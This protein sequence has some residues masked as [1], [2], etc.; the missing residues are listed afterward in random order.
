MYDFLVVG[1]GLFGATFAQVAHENR[2]KVLVVD[3]RPHIAGNAYTED[4]GGII[5]H[6]YGPHIFHT[7]NKLV[8]DYV[9]RFASFN[10]FTNMP[11]ARCDGEMYNMPF[12]MNTF[13]RMWGVVTPEEA[14]AKIDQQ[15]QA[16]GI[17]NPKNLE[18]QAI[19]MVG[20]DIYEKLVKGYTEKQWG[21]PCTDLPP[22]V[23]LRLP[24]RFTYDNSYFTDRYQ[25]IP[26]YGYSAMVARMLDGV[27]VR[28]NVEYLSSRAWLD[29]MARHVIYTGPIDA[30]FDYVFGHLAYRTLSFESHRIG[31]R[32]FQGCAVVNYTAGDVPWTRIT[33]HKWFA[34]SGGDD[35][36][37]PPFTI[38]TKEY[39]AE[40]QPGM[41][42]Y[43]PVRDIESCQ[44]LR[45][46]ED[47]A[48]AVKSRVHFGGRLGMY[49]YIDMDDAIMAALDLANEL[50]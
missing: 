42:P 4:D 43:Y 46:Y 9:R 17:T 37:S 10:R 11:M 27:E 40:C 20:T 19:S 6:R 33:E 22:H 30:Y 3:K 24:V 12:N 34:Y 13:N 15:R 7:D 29:K 50:V 48:E 45:K 21:R 26:E 5:V 39:S 23:I 38:I 44:M 47:A 16:A 2:K 32:N 35:E 14:R 8:W 25:G 41:E 31:V 36:G 1:A 49:R 28:L 18:E